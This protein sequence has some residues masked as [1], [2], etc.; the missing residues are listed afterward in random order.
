MKYVKLRQIPPEGFMSYFREQKLNQ[1]HGLLQR[2][3]LIFLCI[4]LIP[5]REIT[6][7]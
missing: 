4:L 6:R 1:H 3:K 5:L 7:L 2:L